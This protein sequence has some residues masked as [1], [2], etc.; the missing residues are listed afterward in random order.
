MV[1]KFVPGDRYD[2]DQLLAFKVFFLQDVISASLDL[3]KYESY[4]KYGLP[5]FRVGIL[6]RTMGLEEA[7]RN[8]EVIN[9]AIEEQSP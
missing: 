7:V 9:Q 4:R 1:W 2:I 5:G 3:T 8:L 6:R